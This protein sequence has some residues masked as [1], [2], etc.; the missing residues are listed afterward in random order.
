MEEEKESAESAAKRCKLDPQMATLIHEL[1][2]DAPVAVAAEAAGCVAAPVVHGPPLPASLPAGA[3]LLTQG[4]EA[5]VFSC[6]LH[7]K[8]TVVKERFSKQYR[9]AE[10][11]KKLT[12]RRTNAEAKHLQN[13]KKHGIDAPAVIRVD[14]A[15]RCIY[16]ELVQVRF[17]K[18]L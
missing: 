6:I 17:T 14:S 8:P 3:T 12:T 5:R 2:P 10:L 9:H 15:T 7:G 11:D 18:S 1:A 16:M 4:A 13:C